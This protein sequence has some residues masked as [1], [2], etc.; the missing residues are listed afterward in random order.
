MAQTISNESLDQI[1]YSI[2]GWM[3]LM[4][5]GGEYQKLC[6]L[7]TRLSR[8]CPDF[9]FSKYYYVKNVIEE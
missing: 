9:D 4:G 7:V 3:R 1:L 2:D 6:E 5:Y 8:E